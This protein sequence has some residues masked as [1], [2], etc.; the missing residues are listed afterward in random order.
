M[1][2]IFLLILMLVVAGCSETINIKSETT[3]RTEDGDIVGKI[4]IDAQAVTDCGGMDCFEKKFETCEKATISVEALPNL[5]YFYEIVG[6]KDGGCEV[7]SKFTAN[8]NPDF[9][10]KAMNCVYDNSQQFAAALQDQSKCSGPLHDLLMGFGES[11]PLESDTGSTETDNMEEMANPSE[12]KVS[13]SFPKDVYDVGEKIGKAGADMVYSGP[14]FEGI[15]FVSQEKEGTDR[16][17]Q[18]ILRTTF[19]ADNNPGM[20]LKSFHYGVNEGGAVSSGDLDY[21]DVSGT[22]TYT[23]AVYSCASLEEETGR[24]CSFLRERDLEGLA[25]LATATKIITVR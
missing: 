16:L 11:V 5:V 24:T 4:A 8:P 25:A 2:K 3:L 23:A 14:A 22:S 21:F 12:V 13:I 19:T 20:T 7:S 15:F 18:R 10:N 17:N 1:R 9:V 6:S